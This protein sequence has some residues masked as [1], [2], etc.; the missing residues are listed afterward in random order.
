MQSLFSS[1]LSHILA[2]WCAPGLTGKA[3]NKKPTSLKQTL[4]HRHSLLWT[5]SSNGVTEGQEIGTEQG[6][7]LIG[8][9][10]SKVK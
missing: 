6:S 3:Y 4:L 9:Q 5:P 8:G 10:W 2:Q 7:L 1:A